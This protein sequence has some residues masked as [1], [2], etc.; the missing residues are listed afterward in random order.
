MIS[1]TFKED[2]KVKEESNKLSETN[3]EKKVVG[4]QGNKPKTM[5]NYA[6]PTLDGA[7]VG[8]VNLLINKNNFKIKG[9]VLQMIQ[10]CYHFNGLQDEV[11]H[12]HLQTFLKIYGTFKTKDLRHL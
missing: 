12:A 11:P 9:M 2:S 10:Q 4:D 6:K 3:S 7:S 8:V 5:L 1:L